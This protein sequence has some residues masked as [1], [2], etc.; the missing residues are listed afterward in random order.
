MKKRCTIYLEEK[1]LKNLK[2]FAVEK[3]ITVTDVI[4]GLINQEFG[5]WIKEKK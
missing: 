3:G 5:M 2:I 4:T 1:K